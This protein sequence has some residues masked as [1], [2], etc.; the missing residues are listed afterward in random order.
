MIQFFFSMFP[1]FHYI[2]NIERLQHDHIRRVVPD[3]SNPFEAMTEDEFLR[4]FR[5]NKECTLHLIQRIEHQLPQA[6]N[7]KGKHSSI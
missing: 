7:N 3:R 5:L 6:L 1:N 4:R 2:R